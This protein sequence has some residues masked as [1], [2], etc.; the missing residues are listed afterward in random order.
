MMVAARRAFSKTDEL[1]R[2]GLLSFIIV[3]AVERGAIRLQWI[4]ACVAR[5]TSRGSLH[6]LPRMGITSRRAFFRRAVVPRRRDSDSG[7]QPLKWHPAAF[8][9][10]SAVQLSGLVC[11]DAV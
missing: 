4:L 3:R 1:V 5:L 7:L 2:I 8:T 10:A 9:V 11:G 6:H